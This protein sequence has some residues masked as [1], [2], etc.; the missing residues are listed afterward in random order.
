MILRRVL[1]LTLLLAAMARPAHAACPPAR[2]ILSTI[3][4]AGAVQMLRLAP[5]YTR[6]LD[7]ESDDPDVFLGY[8][9]LDS[10]PL[11][12]AEASALAKLLG[13]SGS[14]DCKSSTAPV[15]PAAVVADVGFGFHS[16]VAIVR[17]VFHVSERQI[18]LEFIN[19]A[20]TRSGLTPSAHKR[21]ET[22]LDAL[23]TRTAGSRKAW[24]ERMS[25]HPSVPPPA[26]QGS[27]EAAS[28]VDVMP[29]AIT[30]VP[31]QYPDL[32][33]EAG[34]DGTVLLRARVNTAGMADSL[35][36]LRSIPMLD[37]AAM[38][39][40]RQWRFRP[41]QRSGVP[42]PAWLEVP[43]KFSLH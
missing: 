7:W 17:A 15:V 32:A 39:A 8:E 9:V 10:N 2:L 43:V 38:T 25:G 42:T 4:D 28:G 12:P 16:D 30:R 3:R 26:A 21:F 41:A 37:E 33:R 27:L 24:D 6:D 29:E 1:G 36:L 23:A 11:L 40:V 35:V 5:R 34:V 19:G 18:E 31:P 22:F 14:Y 13:S 20:H